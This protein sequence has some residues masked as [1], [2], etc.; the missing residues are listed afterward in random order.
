M[1]DNHAQ[2]EQAFRVP[3]SAGGLPFSPRAS[4]N[5]L[6]QFNII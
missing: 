6:A 2:A 5:E 3:A 1:T 4:R